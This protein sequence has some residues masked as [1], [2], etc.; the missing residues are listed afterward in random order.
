M[1]GLLYVCGRGSASL[2]KS[3]A[4]SPARRRMIPRYL[5]TRSVRNLSYQIL[6]YE[7][8]K[9]SKVYCADGTGQSSASWNPISV[10][11]TH[12]SHFHSPNY[13][14]HSHLL[15]RPSSKMG[16]GSCAGGTQLPQIGIVYL[17]G[18][19]YRCNVCPRTQLLAM[20]HMHDGLERI[21]I[22]MMPGV[23]SW[24]SSGRISFQHWILLASRWIFWILGKIQQTEA[25]LPY[26]CAKIHLSTNEHVTVCSKQ[27]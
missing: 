21:P 2:L 12:H 7:V 5:H 1:Q 13:N 8:G 15:S 22:I 16:V 26:N 27:R 17:Y 11:R 3:V 9:G 18:I 20:Q 10:P 6:T 4:P 19:Q 23:N 24:L 25:R 14:V